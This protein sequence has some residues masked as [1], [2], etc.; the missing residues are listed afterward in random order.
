MIGVFDSGLGGLSVLKHFISDLPEYDYIYLGDNARVPYGNKSSDLIYEY[1]C[2]AVDFLFSQGA[3]LIILAC[4]SASSQALR[5]LQLEY[6]PKKYPQKNVLGVVIPLVEKVVFS[7]EISRIGVIGTRA[8][9]NSHVYKKEISK[10]RSGLEVI[11]KATPLLVPLIE[12][13]WLKKTETKMI[14][15][16]YLRELK[17]K[18]V[19]AL[20][21]GCTH[22]PFLLSEIRQIMGK[23]CQVYSPGEVVAESLKNYLSRHQELK[24][25]KSQEAQRLFFA[26]DKQGNFKS[27]GQRFL[28]TKI[29]NINY[30]KLDER[31]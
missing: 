29:E 18:K 7:K 12:E 2:Q 27:M 5:K 30:I 8:T 22:Y 14:L 23:S 11:E 1:S 6:I 17:M 15:K 24:L 21:L 25:K 13:N 16:H 9:I 20:I 31:L 28:G 26:T 4:N 19:Q 3:N 10:L